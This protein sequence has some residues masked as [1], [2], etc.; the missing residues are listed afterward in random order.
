MVICGG[1]V[2][3]YQVPVGA[4]GEKSVSKLVVGVCEY[5]A[6]P[7]NN[8]AVKNGKNLFMIYMI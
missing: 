8:M 6:D 3:S 2:Q 5:P 4:P 7:N 1:F